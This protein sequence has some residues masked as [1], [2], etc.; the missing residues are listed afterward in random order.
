MAPSPT[1]HGSPGGSSFLSGSTPRAALLSGLGTPR[2]A[3]LDTLAPGFGV[4]AVGGGRGAEVESE[5]DCL[6]FVLDGDSQAAGDVPLLPPPDLV[7]GGVAE[8]AGEEPDA[9]V[10]AYLR[11]VQEVPP[12]EVP[13]GGGQ[14]RC[15]T[16]LQAMERV[17]AVRARLAS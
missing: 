10:C 15:V 16:P 5:S 9:A 1:E 8:A 3:L 12:L 13:V 2:V 11:L 14:L 7:A 4:V 6:P 17:A